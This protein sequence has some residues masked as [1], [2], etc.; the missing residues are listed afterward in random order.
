MEA[1]QLVAERG[2]VAAAVSAL[3]AHALGELPFESLA[4]TKALLKQFFSAQPWS[5]S[6]SEALADAVGP[7]TGWWRQ[8]LDADLSVAFGWV[9]G[10]FA[11]RAEGPGDAS[12]TPATATA[13]P[14]DTMHGPLAPVPATPALADTFGGPVVPEVTP[15]PRTLAF[16]TGPIHD[17]ESRSYRS[18]AEAD[19]PRVARLFRSFPELATVLVARDFVALTL[20]RPD[21]WEALLAPVLAVLTEEFGE[22]EVRGDATPTA[23]VDGQAGP[24]AP[25]TPRGRPETRLDQAWRDLGSLDASDPA[26]L[27]RLLAAV[28]APDAAHRQVAAALLGEAPPEVGRAE[29]ARLLADRSRAVRSAALDA[30]V[31]ARREDLRPLLEQALADVDAWV[32]W[33]ALRGLSELGAAGSRDA[34]ASLTADTDFRVRLEAQAALRR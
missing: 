21:R 17:G 30:M 20:R 7:G 34:I 4:P 27:G 24:D 31:D 18:A 14:A 22:G 11:L 9:D 15:N 6:N 28:A 10:R 5:E 33:K 12:G 23:L 32:R 8:P 26:A 13:A 19:D 29:W 25:G 16:R 1:R 3:T 2:L